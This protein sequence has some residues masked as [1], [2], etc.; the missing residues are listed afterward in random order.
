MKVR[1]RNRRKSRY[2][3]HIASRRWGTKQQQRATLQRSKIALKKEEKKTKKNQKKKEKTC[4]HIVGSASATSLLD[5]RRLVHLYPQIHHLPEMRND[6]FINVSS[7]RVNNLCERKKDHEKKFEEIIEEGWTCIFPIFNFR[8][9]G[10]I[11]PQK[12]YTFHYPSTPH[13]SILNACH[14]L[15]DTH[16]YETTASVHST[17]TA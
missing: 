3:N 17:Y 11:R 13:I 16:H 2:I 14:K 7:V 8:I 10:V 6:G 5:Q 15:E 1:Q 9:W 12:I 4:A